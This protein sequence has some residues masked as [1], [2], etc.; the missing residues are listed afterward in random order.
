MLLLLRK[1]KRGGRGGRKRSNDSVFLLWL[2]PSRGWGVS[3]NVED[4]GRDRMLTGCGEE[5][6]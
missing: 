1:T 6:D 4:A 3:W 5:E 2:R